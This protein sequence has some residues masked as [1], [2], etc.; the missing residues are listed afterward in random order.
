MLNEGMTQKVDKCPLCITVL[1]KDRKNEMGIL[2][3]HIL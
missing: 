3:M 2:P 1:D